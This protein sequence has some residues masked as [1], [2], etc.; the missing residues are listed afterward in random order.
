MALTLD[1]INRESYLWTYPR[2]SQWVQARPSVYEDDSGFMGGD[3]ECVTIEHLH[4]AEIEVALLKKNN[5]LQVFIEFYKACLAAEAP[6]PG[7]EYP[8]F[9]EN[10]FD[11]TNAS[12]STVASPC[13]GSEIPADK[14]SV[15]C[16][17][18]VALGK[19]WV[20][21]FGS[22]DFDYV[23]GHRV[24]VSNDQPTEKVSPLIIPIE[25]YVGTVPDFWEREDTEESVGVPAFHCPIP[26]D[27]YASLRTT[28]RSLWTQSGRHWQNRRPETGEQILVITAPGR[29]DG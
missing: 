17:A 28:A 13:D 22:L 23:S 9:I 24:A 18:P 2:P 12:C 27:V 4:E 25:P 11:I 10:A 16:C 19:A 5:F 3:D 7:F 21:V 8:E 20:Q 29:L 26:D 14:S 15:S 1:I 6:L